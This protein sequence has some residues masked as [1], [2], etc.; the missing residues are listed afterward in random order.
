MVLTI[1]LAIIVF[2]VTLILCLNEGDGIIS[3]IIITLTFSIIVGLIFSPLFLSS[4][5]FI[6][7]EEKQYSSVSHK[8]V[9]LKDTE[10]S[11][12]S[13]LLGSGYIKEELYYYYLEETNEG[14]KEREL[15]ASDC[16]IKY[17][18]NPRVVEYTQTGFKKAYHYIYAIPDFLSETYYVIYVP[19][20]SITSE[21]KI[22]LE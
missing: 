14:L 12:G 3:S 5:T 2:V 22:D 8:I 4:N 10:N 1:F 6:P 11:N 13:F 20:G 7:K 16:Y 19:K 17:D 21:F 15:R 9:A 18:D